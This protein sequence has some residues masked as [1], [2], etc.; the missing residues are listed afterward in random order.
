[1]YFMFQF[2]KFLFFSVSFSQIYM[3]AACLEETGEGELISPPT[4]HL[5]GDDS[6]VRRNTGGRSYGKLEK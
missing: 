5:W 2:G 3:S 6:R 1:M 4:E